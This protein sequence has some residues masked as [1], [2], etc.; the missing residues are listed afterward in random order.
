MRKRGGVGGLGDRSLDDDEF[1]AAHPRNGVGLAHEAAQAVR[2]DLQQLVACRMAERVVHRLKLVEVE[3]VNRHHLLALEPA[4]RLLQPLVQQYPVGQIGQR[5]MVGHMLDLDLGLALLGDVFVGGDPAAARH[6]PVANLEGASVL[7]FDDAVLCYVGKRDIGAPSQIFVARH[8]RKAAGFKAQ[9]DDFVERRAGA[10]SAARN[11]IHVDKAVVADDQLVVGVEEAQALRHI[12]DRGVE[13]EVSYPQGLFL[14]LAQFV[15]SLETGVELFAL[16]NVFV[17]RDPAAVGHRAH[18][19][20]DDPPVGEFLNRGVERDIATDTLTDIFVGGSAH[21]EAE[22]EAMLDQFAGRRAGL[23][24]F[25]REPVH[26]DV[27]AVAENHFALRVED[28]NSERQI[29]DGLLEPCAQVG[30][31]RISD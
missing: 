20:G 14:L 12:I 8:R 1:V 15:L 17:G 26:L 11:I 23:H 19:V 22:I 29:V 3:M 9:I 21:L 2:H 30:R 6:R 10:D 25:G 13:L 4:Q 27:A 31:S 24:L 7:Q 16:G 28:D 5:V 18:G